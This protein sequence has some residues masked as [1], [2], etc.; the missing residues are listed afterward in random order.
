MKELAM[1]KL[2]C[3]GSLSGAVLHINLDH[4]L[5]VAVNAWNSSTTE[6]EAG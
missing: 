3:D 6:V 1:G 5:D 4:E 2:G